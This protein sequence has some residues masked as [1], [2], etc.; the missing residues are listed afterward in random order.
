M[1]LDES[2]HVGRPVI[3]LPK[4]NGRSKIERHNG[5]AAARG[6][7]GRGRDE[8]VTTADSGIVF[9]ARMH[10]AVDLSRVAIDL[11]ALSGVLRRRLPMTDTDPRV[12]AEFA[13]AAVVC[14]TTPTSAT[15]GRCGRRRIG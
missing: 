15:S 1:T 6:R 8:V 14:D 7:R 5:S 13:R 10:Y 12:V 3:V 9:K 4:V 2:T 11:G